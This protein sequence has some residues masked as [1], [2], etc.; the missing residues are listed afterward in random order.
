MIEARAPQRSRL[1]ML[2]ARMGNPLNW[3]MADKC[4]LGALLL[5]PFV[6]W[7]AVVCYVALRR[8]DLAPYLDQAVLHRA[9]RFQ[10]A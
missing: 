10:L 3:S 4:L 9:F 1:G 7:Y 2:L 5:L 8:P 6:A